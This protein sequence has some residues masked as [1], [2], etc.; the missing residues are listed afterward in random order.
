MPE[1]SDQ[2]TRRAIEASGIVPNVKYTTKDDYAIIAMVEN[3]LG[4]SVMPELLLSGRNYNVAAL[5]A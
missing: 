2:H 1:S 5:E 3:G 4:V